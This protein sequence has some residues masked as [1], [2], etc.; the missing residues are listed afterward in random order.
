M[1]DFFPVNNLVLTSRR[2]P[3]LEDF[4]FSRIFAFQFV[5]IFQKSFGFVAFFF[6]FVAFVLVSVGLFYVFFKRYFLS[7]RSCICLFI[8]A[9]VLFHFKQFLL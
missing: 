9:W 5:N 8:K 2:S 3:L 4:H 6:G 7:G 1:L